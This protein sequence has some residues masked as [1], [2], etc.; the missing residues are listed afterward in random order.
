MALAVNEELEGA[1]NSVEDNTQIEETG[2]T[3]AFVVNSDLES[4]EESEEN[5]IAVGS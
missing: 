4:E 2:D 5:R 3:V 1:E